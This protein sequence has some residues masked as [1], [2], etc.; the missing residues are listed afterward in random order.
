[1][2]IPTPDSGVLGF[3]W[4]REN[5]NRGLAEALHGLLVQVGNAMLV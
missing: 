4:N 2:S 1:M 3:G 5:K